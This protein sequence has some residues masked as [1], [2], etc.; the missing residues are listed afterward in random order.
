MAG[1]PK[2]IAV[3]AALWA[4]TTPGA[5]LLAVGEAL[6]LLHRNTITSVATAI[7]VFPMPCLNDAH[8]P[9][10]AIANVN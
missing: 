9:T 2:Y 10:I 3:F 5:A 1:D 7:A 4:T 6:T 8:A